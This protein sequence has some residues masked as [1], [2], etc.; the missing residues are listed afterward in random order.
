MFYYQ[1][2]NTAKKSAANFCGSNDGS[3]FAAGKEDS[4]ALKEKDGKEKE[5]S[6][7]VKTR[8]DCPTIKLPGKRSQNWQYTR[9]LLAPEENTVMWMMTFHQ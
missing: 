9:H 1:E 2:A 3:T 5:D 7:E 6:P 4:Q 8:E